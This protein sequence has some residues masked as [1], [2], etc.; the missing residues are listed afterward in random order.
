MALLPRTRRLKQ[1]TSRY[2][3]VLMLGDS[4][5][6]TAALLFSEQATAVLSFCPQVDLTESSIRPGACE[7][8]RRTM[9]EAVLAAVTRSD[10]EIT[11]CSGTWQHDLD[12]VNL[13]PQDK[14]EVKVWSYDSHRLALYLSKSG[15][16]TP[17]VRDAVLHQR[18]LRSGN[19]RLSNMV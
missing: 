7:E 10:A 5:G 14:I 19:V 17:L 8:W 16:L 11:L 15:K 6:A 4:M 1:Y 3:R 9:R 2:A 13:L 12:Q 18:S